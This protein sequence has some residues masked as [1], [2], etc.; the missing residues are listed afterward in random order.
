MVGGGWGDAGRIWVEVAVIRA[1]RVRG[2][3]R[4]SVVVVAVKA[5]RMESRQPFSDKGV[6]YSCLLRWDDG[7]GEFGAGGGGGPPAKVGDGAG[8]SGVYV[9]SRRGGERRPRG[10][11]RSQAEREVFA[12]EK[13]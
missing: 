10:L 12:G 7:A 8:G 3:G 5:L 13:K 6:M 1:D 11:A 9:A 2:P 4:E